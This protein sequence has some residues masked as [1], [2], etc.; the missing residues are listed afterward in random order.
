VL[1]KIGDLSERDAPGL[2]A[3]V[4]DLRQRI[5]SGEA[6]DAAPRGTSERWIASFFALP[7]RAGTA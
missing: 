3:A 7:S 4:I 5:A 1:R 2:Q 6:I